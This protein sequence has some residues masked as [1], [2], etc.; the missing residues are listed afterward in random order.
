[1]GTGIPLPMVIRPSQ[2]AIFLKLENFLSLTLLPFNE[3]QFYN[4]L[5]VSFMTD[6]SIL[7]IFS[8]NLTMI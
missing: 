4:I 7:G 5:Y 3:N 1:M 2:E 8:N 6:F